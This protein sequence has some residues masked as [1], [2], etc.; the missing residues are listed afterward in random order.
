MIDEETKWILQNPDTEEEVIDI[1]KK[2][3]LT[4]SQR[5][6]LYEHKLDVGDILHGKF[7]EEDEVLVGQ[8]FEA[9]NK[10]AGFKAFGY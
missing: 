2:H 8:I 6:Q 10:K 7:Y 9:W 1:I 5:K 3:L 4:E